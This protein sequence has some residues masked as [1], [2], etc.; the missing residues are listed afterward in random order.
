[1][2]GTKLLP[3]GIDLCFGLAAAD[4]WCG[5]STVVFVCLVAVVGRPVRFIAPSEYMHDVAFVVVVVVVVV[6]AA[7][8]T[9]AV[10]FRLSFAAE[11]GKADNDDDGCS[12]DD[13]RPA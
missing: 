2:L 9:T 10:I 4:M 1:M 12:I 8:G 6:V 13:E 3:V 7:T 5:L 11:E